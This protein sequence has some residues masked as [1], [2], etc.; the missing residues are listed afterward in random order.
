MTTLTLQ[1]YM[2]STVQKI[3]PIV[4]HANFSSTNDTRMHEQTTSR[5]QLSPGRRLS[6]PDTLEQATL[7]ECT[8]GLKTGEQSM[9]YM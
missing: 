8:L 7:T 3:E 9:I 2:Y 4:I 5:I 1:I 6:H